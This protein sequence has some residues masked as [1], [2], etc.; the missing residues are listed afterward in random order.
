MPTGVSGRENRRLCILPSRSLKITH[1]MIIWCHATT[2]PATSVAPQHAGCTRRALRRDRS[3]GGHRHE[4]PCVAPVG[5]V[6][7]LI[8]SVLLY[9]DLARGWLLFALLFLIPDVSM[10][11][12]MAGHRAGARVYNLF[13]TYTAPLLLAFYGYWLLNAIAL[14]VALIWTAHIGFD[15]LLGYG[16]KLPSGFKDAHL[17]RIG[18]SGQ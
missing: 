16:L 2:T 18:M 1:Q 15:R 12:Y 17:G 6:G 10:L 5:R 13:H 3:S 14:S 11:G 8:G 7:V 9:R 4:C